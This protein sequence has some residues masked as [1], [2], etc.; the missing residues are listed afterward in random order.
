MSEE[1]P[2]YLEHGFKLCQ[3]LV[4]LH[5]DD[6]ESY[7]IYADFLNREQRL[8]EARDMYLYAAQP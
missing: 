2:Q 8:E 1:D 6:P 4:E 5:P 3:M 7:L